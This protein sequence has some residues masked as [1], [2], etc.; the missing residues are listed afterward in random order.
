MGREGKRTRTN[1][2]PIYRSTLPFHSEL[3]ALRSERERLT[4]ALRCGEAA[5]ARGA[6]AE[7]LQVQ[8]TQ[9]QRQLRLSYEACAEASA[10]LLAAREL[11]AARE[12]KLARLTTEVSATRADLAHSR[13]RVAE[14]ATA[15]RPRQLR[16]R[17]SCSV[18]PTQPIWLGCSRCCVHKG[19]R[20]V[21][22]TTPRFSAD[23]DG[24]SW[25]EKETSP[26]L[27]GAS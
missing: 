8:L 25:R 19:R 15:V 21:A 1:S 18:E 14:L 3:C 27:P 10:A 6:E 11:A 13:G 7:T 22:D 26:L 20:A 9:A 17:T 24:R 12:A 2:F 23:C 5:A 16:E 4:E